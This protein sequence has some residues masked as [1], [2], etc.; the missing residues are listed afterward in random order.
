MKKSRNAVFEKPSGLGAGDADAP[1]EHRV[2]AVVEG[3]AVSVGREDESR[4][5]FGQT[6]VH[7]ASGDRDGLF[8][9]DQIGKSY[10]ASE[11][12]GEA[13]ALEVGIDG[14]DEAG[15]FFHLVK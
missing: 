12:A 8:S 15:L 10:L 13:V 3:G 11:V 7:R 4:L 14:G 5:A 2:G 9:V 1:H 6:A